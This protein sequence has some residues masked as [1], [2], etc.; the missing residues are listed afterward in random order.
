MKERCKET[1]QQ[2]FLYID[3][4]VLTENVRQEIKE[5]LEDCAPCLERYGLERE[6]TYLIHRLRDQNHCPDKLRA[7]ITNL[8]EEI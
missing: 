5:H 7:R 1:L 4:E 2:A 3:N 8:I 6:V